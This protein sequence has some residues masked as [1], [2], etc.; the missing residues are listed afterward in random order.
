MKLFGLN[1]L[2][3]EKRKQLVVVALLTA[4]IIAGLGFGLIKYQFSVLAN[5]TA[6][7][8]SIDHRLL[9]MDRMVQR[10]PITEM[11]LAVSSRRLTEMEG[12]MAPRDV[13]SWV[14]TSLREFKQGYK[15]VEIPQ[16]GQP[17]VAD[18]N[19]LPDFPYRQATMRVS[20][21]A[22]YH[23]FGKFLA[24]F[25]NEFP[26]IRVLNLEVTPASTAND[27]GLLSFQFDLVTLVNPNPS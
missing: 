16:V 7:R 4:M 19:L 17:V 1:N 27:K 8:E 24:D 6:K 12:R 9:E 11:E 22:H 18:M 23:D 20:G 21:S 13:Y 14:V 3:S 10:A 15:K 2:S 25:E 5:I 26:H